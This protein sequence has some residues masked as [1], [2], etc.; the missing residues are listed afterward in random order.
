MKLAQAGFGDFLADSG[1]GRLK[2]KSDGNK[3]VYFVDRI[4][5]SAGHK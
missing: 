5:N 1:T 2:G 3:E 4:C